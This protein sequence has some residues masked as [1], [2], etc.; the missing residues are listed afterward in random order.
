MNAPGHREIDLLF[1][2]TGHAI[3]AHV[4]DGWIVDPGPTS[5]LPVLLDALAGE[6]PRGVLLTHIHLDHAGSTGSLLEA[7]GPLPVY[8]HERGARH[9]MDPSRLLASATRLYGDQMDTLW[10]TIVPVPAEHVRVLGDAPDPDGFRWASTPGHAVHH[11][12]FLH[13]ATG[14]AFCGDV[15]GV[16]V[17]D[18]PIQPPTPPPDIDVEAWH[19][20]IATVR[21][22]R[23]AALALA[24][25]GHINDVD[26]HLDRHGETHDRNAQLA[27]ELDAGAFEQE[28]RAILGQASDANGYLKAMPPETLYAGLDR[29]W[30]Q[31]TVERRS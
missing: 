5:S 14:I 13:E 3:C 9:L 11:A 10:G 1:Q 2:S 23:P 19:A 18:G 15:A 22:W 20:S 29:Y 28:V 26:I 17:G 30:A 31:R 12:A 4:I 21:A 25:I 7:L 27:R 24:H 8:V 6:R 16:R